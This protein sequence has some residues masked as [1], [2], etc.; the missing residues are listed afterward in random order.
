[1]SVKSRKRSK[2]SNRT[3]APEVLAQAREVANEYQ[4]IL[5]CEAGTWYGRGLEL[6]LVFG[7][8][9]TPAKC[10]DNTREAFTGVVALML[11][12]GERPPTPAREG[13]RTEQVNVR[14]TAE[15]KA[16]LEATAR[17]KGFKGLSDFIR[18]AA[19][20]SSR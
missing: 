15:E 1:M 13:T 8:G 7:E 3:I 11:E 12:K 16:V 20:E 10:I 17:R 5:V 2:S 4:V 14:L 9:K 6:P 19:L 18:A